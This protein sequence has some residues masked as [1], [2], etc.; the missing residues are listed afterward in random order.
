MRM[1][2]LS[3][4]M[5]SVLT[6]TSVIAIANYFATLSM[7]KKEINKMMHTLDAY[8]TYPSN[9]KAQSA[10][11]KDDH[12]VKALFTIALDLNTRALRSSDKEQSA[13]LLREELV[14][15]ERLRVATRGS[16]DYLTQYAN[17]LTMLH[18]YDKA[19]PL[20][21]KI[22]KSDSWSAKTAEHMSVV[23]K[24]KIK[25]RESGSVSLK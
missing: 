7:G 1:N 11:L 20:W 24:R 14:Y 4:I 23:I 9:E 17:S 25:N 8:D 18:E 2:K 13:R 19:L 3:K 6:V 12:D 16:V 21:E 10:L 15:D 22:A 5:L